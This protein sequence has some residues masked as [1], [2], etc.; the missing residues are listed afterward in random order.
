MYFSFLVFKTSETY[1]FGRL[2][3]NFF[4]KF[5]FRKKKFRQS[6][7]ENFEKSVF[8]K[9]FQSKL[10]FSM[11]NWNLECFQLSFDIHIAYVGKKWQIFKFFILKASKFSKSN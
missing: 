8:C 11:S 5:E 10:Y 4:E 1:K 2:Y 6:R 9:K 3:K 7:G